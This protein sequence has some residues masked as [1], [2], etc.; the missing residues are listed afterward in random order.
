MAEKKKMHK[1]HELV[2]L[3]GAD[4]LEDMLATGIKPR[5][6]AA[7][8]HGQAML[9]DLVAQL[10]DP[11]TVVAKDASKTIQNRIAAIDHVISRQLNEIMHH[12]DFQKLESTWRGLHHLVMNSETGETMKIRMLNMSKKDLLRDF[13]SASEFTESALWKKV[14]ENEFGQYGGDPYGCLV[15]DYE[16]DRGPQDIELLEH[17]SHVA[18]GAHAPFLS[19]A[20]SQMFGLDSFTDMPNPR[21]LAKV[22]DK[23]NP[24]NTKWLS[25]RDSEDARFVALTIPHVL[26]RL[27]YGKATKPVDSFDFEEDV[28]GS[29]DHYLWTNAAFSFA[30]R[31]TDAFAKHHWCVAIRGPEG[32][33]LVE[34]LPIHT[35][36]TREGDVGAKCPTEV[37][38]PD[39]REKELSDLGFIPLIHCKNTDYAAFFGA[40]S[41][42]RPK[43][44]QDD[45]ATANADLSRKI[46][47]LMATARIAHY[48]K[49]ICRDKVGSFA[50][51]SNVQDFL[52]NWINQYVLNQDDAT[53]EQ[54]AKF[55]LREAHIEVTE[56]K[57]RPGCYKAV[58]HLKPHFQLEELNVSLRLVA[59]LPPAAK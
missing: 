37:L 59:D 33:G 47:Y 35:F 11:G 7:R 21:D 23:S 15:G 17:I 40:N 46:Q 41:A 26:G 25:F 28:S 3:E 12:P 1:V 4:I 51:R 55:P 18:A 16:F 29:H 56:D 10:M 22:F 50:A 53:Q 44:Y 38:I 13:Q 34:G 24:E 5:D 27:P 43:V 39:T 9:R 19:A 8:E 6:D 42:Q 30:G 58:A 45:A 48:L 54:K 52:N 57:A 14:Y 49:A 2:E 31:L 32:G 36:K 20:S